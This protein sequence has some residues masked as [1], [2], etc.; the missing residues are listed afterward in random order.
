MNSLCKGC[1]LTSFA[2]PAFTPAHKLQLFQ[3]GGKIFR[4]NNELFSQP[5]WVAVLIGQ[6]LLPER[7]H[8]FVNIKSDEELRELM[9]GVKAGIAKLVSS[10]P[11]HSEF[12]E[13]YSRPPAS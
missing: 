11:L 7:Y 6:G 5:S 12:I 1:E 10:Q 2:M 3:A 13:L 9:A 8:P 4:D